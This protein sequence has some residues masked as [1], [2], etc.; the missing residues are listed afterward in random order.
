MSQRFATGM[1]CSALARYRR[2]SGDV[3]CRA[4]SANRAQRFVRWVLVFDQ[5]VNRPAP[6]VLVF[7]A[8]SSRG[9]PRFRPPVTC[10]AQSARSLRVTSGLSRSMRFQARVDVRVRTALL[11]NPPRMAH[12]PVVAVQLQ[13]DQ[14][15]RRQLREIHLAPTD[16]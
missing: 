7:V 10:S 8:S 3:S 6:D 13:I 16:R 2:T 4:S 1:R 9:L 14:L 15:L 5:E 12:V 11:Q